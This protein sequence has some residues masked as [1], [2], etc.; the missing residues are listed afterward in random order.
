M[1]TMNCENCGTIADCN[2]AGYCDNCACRNCGHSHED[3][4]QACAGQ[5]GEE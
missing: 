1:I 5:D 3:D 4:P 2:S